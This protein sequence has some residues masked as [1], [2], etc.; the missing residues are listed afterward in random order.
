[1][2]FHDCHDV[3]VENAFGKESSLIGLWI[4]WD[5]MITY[6]C[7]SKRIT[8]PEYLTKMSWTLVKYVQWYFSVLSFSASCNCFLR[9]QSHN[10][11]NLCHEN[12][13]HRTTQTKHSFNNGKVYL[14]S[15][16]YHRFKLNNT[17]LIINNSKKLFTFV[18]CSDIFFMFP[19]KFTAK[20]LKWTN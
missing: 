13:F 3:A 15:A 19:H 4:L 8:L 11:T 17:V 7:S 10:K 16:S 6:I 14:Y 2:W 5:R 20:R 18:Q 12:C 9:Q 1:M